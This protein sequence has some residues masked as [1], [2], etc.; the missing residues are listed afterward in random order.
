MTDSALPGIPGDLVGL[1]LG[2]PFPDGDGW[3]TYD[4]A[5]DRMDP[6]LPD[7]FEAVTRDGGWYSAKTGDEVLGV[8]RLN[9]AP[10]PTPAGRAEAW[11]EGFEAGNEWGASAPGPNTGTLADPPRNPYQDDRTPPEPVDS[12]S[13]VNA[14][15]DVIG[16]YFLDHG[17]VT[18][19]LMVRLRQ[20]VAELRRL[21]KLD[22]QVGQR[23]SDDCELN[24]DPVGDQKDIVNLGRSA[25]LNLDAV[26]SEREAV[27]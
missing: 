9:G 1:L 17:H 11:D 2:S 5:G 14:A 25:R 12:P 13:D 22:E 23:I 3:R 27:F 4:A 20:E 6:W 19:D 26:R 24:L 8:V 18:T 21:E 16:S 15:M 10:Q 7:Q